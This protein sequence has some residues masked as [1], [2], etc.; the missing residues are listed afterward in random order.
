MDEK[1]TIKISMTQ[2]VISIERLELS[3]ILPVVIRNWPHNNAS[4]I[5]AAIKAVAIKRG[6]YT[7]AQSHDTQFGGFGKCSFCL[8]RRNCRK[9]CH[10]CKK[11]TCKEHSNRFV[12]C[13]ECQ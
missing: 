13:N 1:Q 5:P 9:Q 11:Y 3:F 2:Q 6:Y 7:M 10:G 8:K 12:L 4:G